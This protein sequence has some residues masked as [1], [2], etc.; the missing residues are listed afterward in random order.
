MI[1]KVSDLVELLNTEY[2]FYLQ[3]DWDNSGFQ[4]GNY[5]DEVGGILLALD[6]TVDSINYAIQNNINCILTPL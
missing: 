3:E 5:E 4:I 6:L 2:S 1:F